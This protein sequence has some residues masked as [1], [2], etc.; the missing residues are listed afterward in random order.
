[1]YS[2]FSMR[3]QGK[4]LL[5]IRFYSYLVALNEQ[6]TCAIGSHA[7]WCDIGNKH[8]HWSDRSG[9]GQC[10]MSSACYQAR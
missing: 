7:H 3:K 6:D 1:M 10:T 5:A 8:A 2:E 9:Y 4:T